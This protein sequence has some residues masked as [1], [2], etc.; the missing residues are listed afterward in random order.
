VVSLSKFQKKWNPRARN[1]Q[2]SGKERTIFGRTTPEFR[3]KLREHGRGVRSFLTKG[4]DMGKQ[5]DHL[6]WAGRQ[7]GAGIGASSA[8][9]RKI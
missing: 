1:P 2:R 5:E 3:G 7:K 9:G 6:K 8:R 4:K